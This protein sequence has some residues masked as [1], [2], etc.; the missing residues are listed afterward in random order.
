MEIIALQQYTDKYVS[1]YQGEIRNINT[2]LAERLIEKKIVRQHIEN[3]DSSDKNNTS[4]LKV[5]IT[6]NGNIVNVTQGTVDKTYD[7][8]VSAYQAGKTIL[9]SMM[10]G[11]GGGPAACV[12]PLA[13]NDYTLLMGSTIMWHYPSSTAYLLQISI[14]NNNCLIESHQLLNA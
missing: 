6:P 1:L 9:A 8:M 14:S 3:E 10:I 12:I 13:Y 2:E 7:E 4:I 11:N 5:T